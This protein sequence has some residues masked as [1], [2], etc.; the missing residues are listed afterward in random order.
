MGPL[1]GEGKKD[2]AAFALTQF[3]VVGDFAGEADAAE[4]RGC[5]SVGSNS[6]VAG[7]ERDVRSTLKSR[8]RQTAP[9]RP[10]CAIGLNQSCFEN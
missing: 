9:A 4:Q 5:V 1:V 10:K 2:R 6:E 3:D 8:R 7:L